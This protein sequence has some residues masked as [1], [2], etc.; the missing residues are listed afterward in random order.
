MNSQ[1]AIKGGDEDSTPHDTTYS[2]FLS[3]CLADWENAL[4]LL[5]SLD[6]C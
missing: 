6:V 3:Q 5:V 2:V 4:F 1:D